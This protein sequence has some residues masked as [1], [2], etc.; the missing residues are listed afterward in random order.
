[1]TPKS[2]AV[3]TVDLDKHELA[4]VLAALRYWQR[5]IET[6]NDVPVTEHFEDGAEP[7]TVEDIDTLCEQINCAEVRP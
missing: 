6:Y 5:Y 7:L 2:Q 1:M 3:V 4:T